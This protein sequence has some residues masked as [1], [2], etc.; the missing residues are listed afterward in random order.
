MDA[1]TNRTT[2]R[3][4]SVALCLLL[5]WP[6]TGAIPATAADNA[7]RVDRTS[8]GSSGSASPGAV[9]ATPEEL[10]DVAV[11][12]PPG[13]YANPLAEGV[14]DDF[15][16]PS[17]IRGRDGYWYAYST[18]T[19]LVPGGT[20]H[21]LPIIRSDDL[22]HWD[23]VGDVF[24]T[25]NWPNW[26]DANS[27][28]WDPA[29]EYIDG[30]YVLYFTGVDIPGFERPNKSIGVATAPT[31]AGPWT[32]SGEPLVGPRYYQRPPHNVRRHMSVIAP[33]G[34]Q[35]ADGRRYLYYGG[36]NG[37]VWGLPVSDDGLAAAGDEV[38]LVGDVHLEGPYV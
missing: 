18:R 35:A 14:A 28:T 17:T 25:S 13:R 2:P 1:S 31:P 26:L 38:K 7:P 15:P 29:I 11:T 30:R 34:V 8:A 24:G 4:C 3:S 27:S 37:G 19:P 32:D 10:R 21:N 12:R 5:A 33:D 16:D 6:V 9:A 23:Y 22:V 36:F 20:R